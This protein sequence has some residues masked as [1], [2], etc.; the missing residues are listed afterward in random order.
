MVLSAPHPLPGSLSLDFFNLLLIL[1]KNVH[2]H[3]RMIE[4]LRSLRQRGITPNRRSY[5]AVISAYQNEGNESP[6]MDFFWEMTEERGMRPSDAVV[7]M[8][9]RAVVSVKWVEAAC[10]LLQVLH[11]FKIKPSGILWDELDK[12]L[13]GGGRSIE[14]EW[15]ML[16][17]QDGDSRAEWHAVLHGSHKVDGSRNQHSRSKG[18]HEELDDESNFT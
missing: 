7:R 3:D 8:A 11:G 1:Y 4:I 12:V 2:D 16:C 17:Q 14:E 15:S 6:L 13:R 9:V 5:E 18:F 10:H